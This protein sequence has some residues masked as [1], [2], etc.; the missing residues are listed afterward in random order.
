MEFIEYFSLEIVN[1]DVA[2]F[3]KR[4]IQRVAHQPFPIVPIRASNKEMA[5]PLG[6]RRVGYILNFQRYRIT[7]EGEYALEVVPVEEINPAHIIGVPP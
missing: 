1:R 6:D 7:T 2:V 3:I 5:I 4:D